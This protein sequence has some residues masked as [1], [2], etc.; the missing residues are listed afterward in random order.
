[1]CF[2]PHIRLE[3]MSE[4]VK[5]CDHI[6]FNSF[7]QLEQHRAACK[8]AGVS[9]GIRVNPECSTQAG[10]EIYDPCAPFSRLGVT[11]ANFRPDLLDGVEGL[12]FHTLC[13]QDSGDLVTDV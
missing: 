5:I 2:R 11:R 7:S 6:V 13:E 3:E 9:I 8:Q 4:L 12:H 10:H 1:M